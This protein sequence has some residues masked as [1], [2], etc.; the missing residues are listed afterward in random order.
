[1]KKTLYDYKEAIKQLPLK[2][3]YT[4]DEILVDKFLVDKEKI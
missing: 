1:M 4:K 2:D 3:K